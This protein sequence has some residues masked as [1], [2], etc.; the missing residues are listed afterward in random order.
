MRS[1]ECELHAPEYSRHA[2]AVDMPVHSSNCVLWK[3]T[4]GSVLSEPGGA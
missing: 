1:A 3:I 4:E 2:H